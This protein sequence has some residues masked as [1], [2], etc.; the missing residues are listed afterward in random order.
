MR[1]RIEPSN[2]F[3]W[4]SCPGSCL[5]IPF[6]WKTQLKMP[7]SFQVGRCA[8]LHCG[9]LCA[10][11]TGSMQHSIFLDSF[12]CPTSHFRFHRYYPHHWRVHYCLFRQLLNY[13]YCSLEFHYIF[14]PWSR[15]C[16]YMI[17][18][19]YQLKLDLASYYM[20]FLVT[21]SYSNKFNLLYF[22]QVIIFVEYLGY[23]SDYYI[24]FS[25][26]CL[27]Y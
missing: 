2:N 23:V 19:I 24:Y 9:A 7:F 10:L 20:Y 12:V 18:D 11:H 13:Y 27:F 8:L 21:E 16:I 3:L 25:T 4:D 14:N 15:N 26:N 6:L 22:Y 17:H 1:K 5:P